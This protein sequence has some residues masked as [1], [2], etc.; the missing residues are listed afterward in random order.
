MVECR[1]G[2]G[3]SPPNEDLAGLDTIESELSDIVFTSIDDSSDRLPF[4]GSD[5]VEADGYVAKN[6]D[7]P[8]WGM[9]FE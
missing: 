5:E 1:N 2:F 9:D 6:G 3:A 8:L 4:V 7:C